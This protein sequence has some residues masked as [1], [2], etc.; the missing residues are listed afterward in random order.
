[1]YNIECGGIC[2][3]GKYSKVLKKL[4]LTLLKSLLDSKIGNLIFSLMTVWTMWIWAAIKLNELLYWK[5]KTW[6]I[7]NLKAEI[8]SLNKY[9]IKIKK[10]N[11]SDEFYTGRHM[12]QHNYLCWSNF[13]LSNITTLS[14][15]KTIESSQKPPT[16]TRKIPSLLK[17]SPLSS[18]LFNQQW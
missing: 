5:P 6:S 9:T 7:G 10:K 4:F 18:I 1:M 14:R 3:F 8:K 2:H 13:T 12:V 17:G 16:M 15:L 11:V